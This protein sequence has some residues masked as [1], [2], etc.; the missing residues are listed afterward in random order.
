MRTIWPRTSRLLHRRLRRPLARALPT[1]HTMVGSFV[2]YLYFGMLNWTIYF[3]RLLGV[4]YIIALYVLACT[5]VALN[6]NSC[7]EVTHNVAS[8]R[9][10][11]CEQISVDL[12]SSRGPLLPGVNSGTILAIE[13]GNCAV[14]MIEK[15]R[16][17]RMGKFL[18]IEFAPISHLSIKGK[19]SA[20]QVATR[21]NSNAS[22]P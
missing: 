4:K 8:S 5:R 21:F 17:L 20:P 12:G 10:K 6:Q 1:N 18:E 16:L 2:S 3:S 14:L 11:Y 15:Q 7:L 13:T 22:E 9:R 19:Y